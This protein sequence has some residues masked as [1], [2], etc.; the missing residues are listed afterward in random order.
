VAVIHRYWSDNSVEVFCEMSSGIVI[1]QQMTLVGRSRP[2][3]YRHLPPGPMPK[4][5]EAGRW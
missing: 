4:L 5:P 1:R 2:Q 3:G